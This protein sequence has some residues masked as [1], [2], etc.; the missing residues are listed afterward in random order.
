MSDPLK[1][2]TLHLFHAQ[3]LTERHSVQ[4]V[5]IVF[6]V[7]MPSSQSSSQSSSLAQFR[8]QAVLLA[9]ALHATLPGGTLSALR[10]E[11]L[12]R[13]VNQLRVP[14]HVPL[15]LDVDDECPRC[16]LLKIDEVGP[17]SKKEPR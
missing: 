3:P 9:D 14:D 6:D 7:P 8:D 13:A 2:R 12:Q 17:A 4:P 16:R 5:A 1:I 10:A 11:L 15:A